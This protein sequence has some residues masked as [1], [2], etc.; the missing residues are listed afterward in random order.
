MNKG[1]EI[2]IKPQGQFACLGSQLVKVIESIQDKTLNCYWLVGD[3][4]IG[5]YQLGIDMNKKK[6]YREDKKVVKYELDELKELILDVNQFLW[7]VF[8]AIPKEIKID[9]DNLKLWS[10]Q[11][12]EKQIPESLVE[13]RTFD[14][15]YFLVCTDDKGIREVFEKMNLD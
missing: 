15:E 13:I 2:I 12:Y 7:G 8:V 10:E 9:I 4:E 1:K 3:V 11:P 5:A 14:A 6:L